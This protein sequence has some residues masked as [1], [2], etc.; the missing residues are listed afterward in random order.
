[1]RRDD[2]GKGLVVSG[3][4]FQVAPQTGNQKDI[5]HAW[6]PTSFSTVAHFG[7]ADLPVQPVVRDRDRG[8]VNA[9]K[10]DCK[11]ARAANCSHLLVPRP[12]CC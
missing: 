3:P 9:V 8:P 12:S 11:R 5:A 2:L 6:L 4:H 1:M 7:K 10:L